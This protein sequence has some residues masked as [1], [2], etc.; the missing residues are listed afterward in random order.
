MSDNPHT[1]GF[2]TRERYRRDGDAR[3]KQAIIEALL[4]DACISTNIPVQMLERITQ[5]IED[6]KPA[7]V[8][9]TPCCLDCK[10]F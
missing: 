9:K 4:D 6:T 5:I 2:E 3:T 10:V 7:E 1:P 8:K